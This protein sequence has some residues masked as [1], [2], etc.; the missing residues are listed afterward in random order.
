AALGEL[1]HAGATVSEVTVPSLDHAGPALGALIRGEAR[2]ALAPLLRARWE[3][4]SVEL[5]VYLELGKLV[6]AEQYLAA[7]RLRTR[8]Y[9]E[10]RAALTRVDLLATPATVLAAPR[11]DELQ[12]RVGDTEMGTLEAVCRLSG[13]FNLTGLPAPALPC[14][15]VSRT[16]GPARGRPAG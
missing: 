4:V 8:L 9:D 15:A 6:S 2:S 1:G 14:C 5:R 12:V 16:A 11:L 10:M 13:P 3:R 7:Q